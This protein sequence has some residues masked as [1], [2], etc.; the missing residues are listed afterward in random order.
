MNATK[1]SIAKKEPP[2]ITFAEPFAIHKTV[3]P[4]PPSDV[5]YL[6]WHP[7]I[8]FLLLEEGEFDFFVENDCYHMQ[9][10]DATA[11]MNVAIHYQNGWGVDKDLSL[12]AKWYRK[13]AEAGNVSAKSRLEECLRLMR[14]SAQ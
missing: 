5:L 13:S 12:A 8:E 10:G 7:E 11:Q 9:R 4:H 6:H 3:K 2:H 14:A 1:F